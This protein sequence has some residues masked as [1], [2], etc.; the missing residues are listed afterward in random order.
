MARGDPDRLRAREEDVP[1]QSRRLGES[2]QVS[3]TEVRADLLAR[4][5]QAARDVERE[6]RRISER[7][8]SG[9][10]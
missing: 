6:L 3:R 10:V 9:I 4:A 1:E 8:S 2:E 7:M 5:S